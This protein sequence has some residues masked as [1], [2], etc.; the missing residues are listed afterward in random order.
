[1]D[2]TTL[3]IRTAPKKDPDAKTRTFSVQLLGFLAADALWEPGGMA[4]PTG[5]CG[6]P[7]P[8]P[9]AKRI[10]SPPTSAAAGRPRPR[11]MSSSS[12]G[13]VPTAGRRRRCPAE[14]SPSPTSLM[15]PAE[16]GHVSQMARFLGATVQAA[17]QKLDSVLA[18][19]GVRPCEK[20]GPFPFVAGQRGRRLE[21]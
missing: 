11:A 17:P 21:F 6:S 3:T 13:A 20:K 15:R 19:A 2:F 1:M 16:W 8:A 5:R 10:R 9:S 4:R 18:V 7:T 12:P 14:S